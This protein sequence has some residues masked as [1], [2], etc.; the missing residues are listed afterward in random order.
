MNNPRNLSDSLPTPEKYKD[1]TMTKFFEMHPELIGSLEAIQVSYNDQDFALVRSKKRPELAALYFN[2]SNKYRFSENLNFKITDPNSENPIEIKFEYFCACC[3]ALVPNDTS[4]INQ[5]ELKNKEKPVL[6]YREKIE[7]DLTDKV[8]I[9]FNKATSEFNESVD[10]LNT[11]TLIINDRLRRLK[12]Q[13]KIKNLETVKLMEKI[14]EKCIDVGVKTLII[15]SASLINSGNL[16]RH[17]KTL[18][19][20]I[21]IKSSVLDIRD[22]WFGDLFYDGKNEGYSDDLEYLLMN[23]REL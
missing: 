22:W 20:N 15:Q 14:D 23:H 7:E 8:E 17:Y 5:I 2:N 16:G 3:D 18:K 19:S 1:I 11:V 9:E 10:K 21:Y 13:L 12:K 4:I 6:E